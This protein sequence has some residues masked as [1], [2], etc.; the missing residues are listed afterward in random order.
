MISHA[1]QQFKDLLQQKKY[2]EAAM[3]AENEFM[4]KGEGD[5]FW[6]TQKSAA[7]LRAGKYHEAFDAAKKALSIDPRNP[8]SILA[9]ADALSGMEKYREAET[10]Y[11]EIMQNDRLK[12][13]VHRGILACL[14]SQKEWQKILEILPELKTKDETSFR[15]E[16]KAL[17]GLGQNDKAGELCNAWLKNHPDD[18]TALWALTEIEIQTL[19]LNKVLEKM[20]R[21]SQ[22]PSRPKIY[23]EIYASLCRRAGIPDKAL[24]QYTKM[25]QK[26][27]NPQILRQLAFT[28]AKSGQ[29]KEALPIFE[30]LLRSYP[31]DTYINSAYIG[32]LGR[33]K[34]PERG[35]QFYDDLLKLYPEE[36]RLYGYKKRLFKKK[37]NDG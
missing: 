8:F 12:H 20:R 17:R 25:I 23:G 13:R 18:Y 10:Y 14:E 11:Y 21:L 4:R 30:E 9:A 16:V 31:K 28:K 35:I 22:I 36:K 27:N 24:N 29:E 32:A 34:E 19:G 7:L 15:M 37:D 6:L 33:I 5:D 2:L 1:Y 26:E 3:L